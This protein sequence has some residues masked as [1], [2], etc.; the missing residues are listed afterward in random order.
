[1]ICE[2]SVPDDQSLLDYSIRKKSVANEVMCLVIFFVCESC[3]NYT[4]I[5]RG[6]KRSVG[7]EEDVGIIF[8][9]ESSSS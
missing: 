6:M 1:M 9:K 5:A 8:A 7:M 2:P 3:Y 4:L